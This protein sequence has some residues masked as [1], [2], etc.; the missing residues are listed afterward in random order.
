MIT[1]LAHLVY[2]HPRADDVDEPE[3]YAEAAEQAARQRGEWELNLRDMVDATGEDPL[4]AT[5]AELAEQR[6]EAERTIRTVMA[7]G[8]HALPGRGYSWPRMA[9]AAQMNRN[10]AERRVSAA[11]VA[12]VCTQLREL[13]E[14]E[15]QKRHD[16]ARSIESIPFTGDR[17]TDLRTAYDYGCPLRVIDGPLARPAT[18]GGFE[19]VDGTWHPPERVQAERLAQ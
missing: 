13:E 11:H 14:E 19:D 8:G 6:D 10:T 17:E 12:D 4:L 3:A 1:D 5:L 7:Y 15:R 2:P 9:A 16:R 18:G